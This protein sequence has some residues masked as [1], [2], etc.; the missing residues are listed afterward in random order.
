MT[1]RQIDTL[2]RLLQQTSTLLLILSGGR[3]TSLSAFQTFASVYGQDG[4]GEAVCSVA[5]C[6]YM[7]HVLWL[8]ALV[9]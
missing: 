2:E 6:V 3:E 8:L 5:N 7:L 4:A 9:S 1:V